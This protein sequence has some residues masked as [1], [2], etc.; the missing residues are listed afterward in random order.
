MLKMQRYQNETWSGFCQGKNA[1][2]QPDTS[3][4]ASANTVETCVLICM[5][6]LSTHFFTDHK[7]ARV[8]KVRIPCLQKFF[9]ISG[10]V[11]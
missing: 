8:E 2:A 3:Q 11:L 4:E 9:A 10:L 6:Q 5:C 7:Y 1:Q